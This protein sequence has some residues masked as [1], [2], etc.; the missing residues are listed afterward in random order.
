MCCFPA[1]DLSVISNGRVSLTSRIMGLALL[2]PD[3]WSS[4]PGK[5]NIDGIALFKRAALFL[6]RTLYLKSSGLKWRLQTFCCFTASKAV[7]SPNFG[8]LIARSHCLQRSK[9]LGRRWKL[10]A[11]AF[12]VPLEHPGTMQK[13]P[14]S[15]EIQTSSWK[16][17]VASSFVLF[18][19]AIGKQLAYI[20][21]TYGCGINNLLLKVNTYQIIIIKKCI[22]YIFSN[23]LDTLRKWKHLLTLFGI[24]L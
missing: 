15:K 24:I 16:S 6:P 20:T 10:T 1:E 19:L 22:A 9:S 17:D 23:K 18:F 2:V 4:S 12:L 11:S 21:A 7:S 8:W 3:G 13:Y 5:V 14:I